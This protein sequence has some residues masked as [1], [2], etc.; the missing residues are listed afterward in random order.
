MA[1]ISWGK[2]TIK[3]GKLGENDAA[4]TDWIDI[5]TPVQGSTIL[6]TTKGEKTEAPLEGGGFEDVRYNK[7][8]Y[9]LEFELYAKKGREKPVEDLDGVVSGLYA[10]KLQPEDP[11]VD[12]ISITKGVLSVED[13]WD[14]SIGG[15]WK[16]TLD[17][18][19]P[20]TGNQ[21]EWEVVTF[22]PNP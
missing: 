14:A 21:V 1:Q 5:P 4:P 8:T 16:Y 15:K 22:T 10:L 12:G 7:N 6:T 20:S 13:T 19:I 17:V 2:P 3:I 18:L 9:T 11:T